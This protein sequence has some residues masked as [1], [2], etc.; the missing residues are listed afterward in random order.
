MARRR[1]PLW[2]YVVYVGVCALEGLLAAAI[3]FGLAYSQELALWNWTV[4]LGPDLYV[5]GGMALF[6][7][8]VTAWSSWRER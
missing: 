7:F 4:S 2:M 1:Y 6:A 3:V 5:A 8:L